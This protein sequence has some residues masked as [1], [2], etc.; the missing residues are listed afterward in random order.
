D[1]DVALY[2]SLL[3]SNKV[4]SS[5]ENIATLID[6]VDYDRLIT[7]FISS[8]DGKI[9]G[10]FFGIEGLSQI[11]L[12]D[13]LLESQFD[14]NVFENIAKSID[15]TFTLN[16]TYAANK[17]SKQ[18]ILAGCFKYNVQDMQFLK[19]TSSKFP[20][21][22]CHQD[23]IIKEMAKFF[24][25]ITFAESF[26]RSIID[27]PQLCIDFKKEFWSVCGGKTDIKGIELQVVE[28]L[29]NNNCMIPE[30]L[31]YKFTDANLETSLK[32]TLLSLAVSQNQIK[33]LSSYKEYFKSMGEEYSNLWT[34][35][36]R[37]TIQDTKE[38][39]VIVDFMR[40]NKLANYT[41]R[42]G[43]LYLRCV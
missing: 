37:A 26:G 28:F 21:Y 16:S 8:N 19:N 1:V 5:W 3:L 9:A 33:D 24:D 41:P 25:G 39:R 15:C 2:E 32:S 7:S 4:V 35:T 42:K 43:S 18:F 34:E 29:I 13:A 17:N 11:E 12:F 31:L 30:E 10:S 20:Y 6:K 14:E 22:I 23:K 36:Q 38:N 40:D 27:E